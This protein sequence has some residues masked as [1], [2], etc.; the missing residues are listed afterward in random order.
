MIGF[1][2]TFCVYYILF[3]YW[4][5]LVLGLDISGVKGLSIVNS[6]IYLSLLIW[7]ITIIKKRSF[8]EWNEIYKYM[9]LFIF[10]A[11]ISVP[12]KMLFWKLNRVNIIQEIVQLKNMAENF[13]LFFVLYN[14]L[15][16]KKLCIISLWGLMALFLIGNM[17]MLLDWYNVINLPGINKSWLE[18]SSGFGNPND[19]AA[20][21]LLFLPLL[22]SKL[23]ITKERFFRLAILFCIIISLVAF[24]MTGS[25]GGFISFI[26]GISV[27]IFFLKKYLQ[28]SLKFFLTK[29]F[30]LVLPLIIISFLIIPESYVQKL[31]G[32]LVVKSGENL[33]D[34]S[35]GRSTFWIGGIK[36]FLESPIYGHG[37]N[38][39]SSLLKKETGKNA[40]AHNRYLL[41]LVEFGIIG[42]FAFLL[43]QIS[44]FRQVLKNLKVVNNR[45]EILLHIS[46]LTGIISY[47]ISIIFVD[48]KVIDIPFWIYAATITRYGRISLSD[49]KISI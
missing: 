7:G 37:M 39:F 13:T 11:L 4:S 10:L 9:L 44:L 24:L 15:E 49:N 30:I 36:I 26:F 42:F 43:M 38:T 45:R 28:L 3:G 41:I 21:M 14:L 47:F 20:Y 46:F 17:T 27:Y 40:A 48:A 6:G 8:I 34:Y 2:V 12:L 5:D 18:E 22:F 25:R 33:D 16:N 32:D 31:K 29:L 1:L 19:Y 23:L 35:H